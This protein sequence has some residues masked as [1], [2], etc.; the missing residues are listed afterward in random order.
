MRTL[1]DYLRPGLDIV[2]VGIN[3]GSYSAQVGH[4][5][6]TP[7]NR[8]WR[9]LNR[10]GLVPPGRELGPEDDAGMNGLGIGFTDVVKRASPGAAD[11]T[12]ADYARGA[13]LLR[14]KLLAAGPRIVCFNGLT[15]AANYLRYAEG[16]PAK[17]MLGPQP[18]HIGVSQVFVAPNPSPANAAFSLDVLV[19]WY[20]RLRL[21][22]DQ[23]AP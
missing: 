10:S 11:L 12:A 2:F 7:R 17:V 1:P 9:A 21:L 19:T 6:A 8:F 22:R 18:W 13:P 20:S 15:A 4:Y 14:E 16:A 3:P 5:F 23:G